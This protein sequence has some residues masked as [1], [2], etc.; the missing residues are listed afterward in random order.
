MSHGNN[1]NLFYLELLQTFLE[2]S[3]PTLRNNIIRTVT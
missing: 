2:S 1:V 3:I